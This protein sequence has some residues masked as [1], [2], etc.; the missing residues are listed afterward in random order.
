MGRIGDAIS[1]T[2]D[3]TKFSIPKDT[4]PMKYDGGETISESQTYGDGTSDAYVSIEAAKITGIKVKVNDDNIDDFKDKKA[5]TNI[6]FVLQTVSKTYEITGHIVGNPGIST[7]KSV[8]E[9]FEIHCSDG[10]GIRES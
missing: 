6:P 10:T 3:G 9:E 2:I 7:T 4:E 1:L 5:Q 8:T